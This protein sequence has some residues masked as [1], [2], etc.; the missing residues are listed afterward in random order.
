MR[1][2]P[3]A[4]EVCSRMGISRQAFY[5]RLK[6]QWVLD[7][8]AGILYAPRRAKAVSVAQSQ[9]DVS[10]VLRGWKR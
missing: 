6:A 3:L 5:K 10:R 2:H 8:R 4:A 1:P 9:A 7:D